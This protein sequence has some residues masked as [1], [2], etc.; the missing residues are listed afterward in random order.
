MNKVLWTAGDK[1]VTVLKLILAAVAIA[2]GVWIANIQPP[3]QMTV[4][5]MR[6]LGIIVT[7]IILM[8]LRIMAE[9]AWSMLMLCSFVVFK[10][11]N[12]S[13]AFAA[14]SSSVV[15]TM[16]CA[17]A[18]GYTASKTGVLRRIAFHVLKL[19]PQNYY[20]QVAAMM[21]AGTVIEPL[22]PSI[23][24]KVVIMAPL[25]VSVTKDLQFQKSSKGAAGLFNA[26]WISSGV[27]GH[28]FMNGSAVSFAILALL[29]EQAGF[30]TW[31]KWLL[32]T[33]IWLVGTIV[34][35]YF[36]IMA[37]YKPSREEANRYG[38]D[39]AKNMLK[40]MGPMNKD[41]K[42]VAVIIAVLLLGFITNP[43]HKID[44]AVISAIC[45]GVAMIV[46]QFSVKD[47]R[48]G[49]PWEAILLQGSVMALASGITGLGVDKWLVAVL[50]P[51][52]APIVSHKYLLILVLCLITYALRTFIMS[53]VSTM[54]I[55]YFIFAASATAAG[56]HPW[57]LMFVVASAG[58]L[59]TFS[60]QHNIYVAC[61]GATNHETVEHR[62]VY[63]MSL[64]YMAMC[65][66][67]MLASVPL[68]TAMGM[69]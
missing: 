12:Y 65:L 25:S 18:V 53:P 47:V 63:Q 49:I 34:L 3:E 55:C 38:S 64:V 41:E 57:V 7:F 22:V 31:G 43:W 67:L 16:V 19:F 44:A 52:M 21:L 32:A 40:S 61:I 48:T 23:T 69:M 2:I 46:G 26:M 24:A 13:T 66:L 68:W 10:A 6:F 20:G 35:S 27:I 58:S 5:S 17:S 54:T 30:F 39:F 4:E 11:T 42:I 9:S 51:V 62:D 50:S 60:F 14:F 59:W 1:K 8:C 28:A 33:S 56:I 29:G 37:L 15:W 36:G 45:M